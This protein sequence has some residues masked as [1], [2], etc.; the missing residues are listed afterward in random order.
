MTAKAPAFRTPLS[1]SPARGRRALDVA[2]A[3]VVALLALPFLALA[4]QLLTPEYEIW[5]HLADTVL[6]HYL[7][8]SL[9][10][11]AGVTIGTFLLGVPTAWLCSVCEF[12]MR[13]FFELALILPLA[14]PAYIAAYV[15]TGI[16]D[17]GGAAHA[18]LSAAGFPTPAPIRSLGGAITV[19]TLVLYPYVYLLARASFTQQSNRIIEAGRT[20][21]ASPRG[22][23]LHVALPAARPAIIAGGALVMM[24]TLADFGA[25][26]YF[27]VS[28]FSV[29]IFRTWFGL[30]SIAGAAQLSLLLLAF[31]VALLVTEKRARRRAR[32]Y[33]VE[34][35]PAAPSYRLHGVRA[36]GAV[37]ACALPLLLGFAVPTLQLLAWAAE[38]L[39][40]TEIWDY[41]ALIANSFSL[42]LAGSL[43]I[44]TLAAVISYAKRL[45]PTAGVKLAVQT[46]SSGYAV[47]GVVIA[48]GVLILFS[49]FDRWGGLALGGGFIALTFAYTIRFLTLG[50]N[51]VEAALE[52]VSPNLDHA[53]HALGASTPE[54]LVRIHLPLIR[55][56]LLTAALL[57]FVEIIKEL[58][59]TLVL[60]PFNFNT[61]AVRAFELASDERL[62]DVAL[63][64]LSI[65]AVGVLPLIALAKATRR[66]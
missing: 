51:P 56:G 38:R 33:D 39:P 13:R 21:G 42:A 25:V 28:T 8:E 20:L 1:F 31:V 46:V 30:G 58:P 19:L 32:Y 3:A 55:G 47:P 36:A 12:P 66:S 54:T 23:F 22:C 40:E 64:A 17:Y 6:K 26:A 61:L 5:S 14:Y 62:A 34:P 24:E 57:V 41:A 52:K 18:W 65:V 7:I 16:F 59:A 9:A 49:A 37:T 48:I 60:R 15:Y 10:L 35:G 29:G 45:C 2:T 11:C 43:V 63:P 27:G 53:A 4:A 50:F 44:L